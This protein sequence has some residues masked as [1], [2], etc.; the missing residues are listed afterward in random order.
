MA[1]RSPHGVRAQF[2]PGCSSAG[3][4]VTWSA[5]LQGVRGPWRLAEVLTPHMGVL[6]V[7]LGLFGRSDFFKASSS[8]R[9]DPQEPSGH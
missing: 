1:A 2:S 8:G 5:L 7:G 6:G 9:P 3:Q 4:G